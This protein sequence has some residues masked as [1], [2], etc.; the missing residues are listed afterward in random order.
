MS[1]LLKREVIEAAE[2]WL[3]SWPELDELERRGALGPGEQRL[4]RAVKALRDARR[5]R[6]ANLANN[7]GQG[8]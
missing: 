5:A 1:V 8:D 7:S 2:A 6:L 3:D 4:Y